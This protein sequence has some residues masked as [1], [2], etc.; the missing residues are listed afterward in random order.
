MTWTNEPPKLP[1][2]TT[3]IHLLCI[4]KSFSV[5]NRIKM[6]QPDDPLGLCEVVKL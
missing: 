3:D 4:V 5:N 1:F 6:I 2:S